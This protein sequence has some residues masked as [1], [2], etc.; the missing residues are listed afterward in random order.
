MSDSSPAVPEAA[1]E[2]GRDALFNDGE[3]LARWCG[4]CSGEMCDDCIAIRDDAAKAV[5]A[6]ALPHIREQIAQEI[7][8]SKATQR[9]ATDHEPRWAAGACKCG[10]PIGDSIDMHWHMVNQS[11]EHAARIVRGTP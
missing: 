11:I 1:I 2:A 4:V 10:S 6:A 9:V 5:I 7:E 8:A 3:N